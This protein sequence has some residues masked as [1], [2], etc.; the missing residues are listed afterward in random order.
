MEH[1]HATTCRSH[2]WQEERIEEGRDANDA[3]EGDVQGANETPHRSGSASGV[4]P[5]SQRKDQHDTGEGQIA[6]APRL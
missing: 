4:Q 5:Q 3:A 6:G 1:S 2:G